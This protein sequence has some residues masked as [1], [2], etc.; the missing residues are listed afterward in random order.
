MGEETK[1]SL[2]DKDNAQFAK[3]IEFA[4]NLQAS[5]KECWQSCLV[6]FVFIVKDKVVDV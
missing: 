5:A 1:F 3:L 4:C 6:N 2:V